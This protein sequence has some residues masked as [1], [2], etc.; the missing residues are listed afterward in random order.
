MLAAFLIHEK[1]LKSITYITAVKN[2]WADIFFEKK[3]TIF[4][5]LLHLII[6]WSWQHL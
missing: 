2:K 6:A 3:F 1:V 5:D 4:V